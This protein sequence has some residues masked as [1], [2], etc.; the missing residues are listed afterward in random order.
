MKLVL[1]LRGEVR[2]RMDL[3][4]HGN[5]A[6]SSDSSAPCGMASTRCFSST[7]V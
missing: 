5:E 1:L 3:S 6:S 7:S 4:L 2:R